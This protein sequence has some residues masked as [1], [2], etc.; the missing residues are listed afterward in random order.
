MSDEQN[1]KLLCYIKGCI[2]ALPKVDK[3]QDKIILNISRAISGVMRQEN[4]KQ[5]I[6]RFKND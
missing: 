1:L 3:H 2:E 6:D 5:F 4:E